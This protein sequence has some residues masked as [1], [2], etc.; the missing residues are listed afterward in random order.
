MVGESSESLLQ[1]ISANR[2]RQLIIETEISKYGDDRTCF[3]PPLHGIRNLSWK[4]SSILDFIFDEI[5]VQVINLWKGN[6][7]M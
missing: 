6:R 4:V 3:A 2:N 7:K 1:K 5:D